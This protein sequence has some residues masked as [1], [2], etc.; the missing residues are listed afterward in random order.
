MD[1]KHKL[2][3]AQDILEQLGLPKKGR[4]KIAALTLFALAGLLPEDEWQQA[5]AQSLT[6]SKDIIDFVNTH[7]DAGYKANTR[8]SFRKDA[9]KPFVDYHIALLNPDDPELST[10]SSKTHYALSDK[11]LKVIKAYKTAGWDEALQEFK[12]QQFTQQEP[13]A[14]LLQKISIKNY[15]SVL[16]DTI[17]LGRFNV[18]IGANGCGKSNLLEAIAT[19]GAF[20]ANELTFEGLYARGVRTARPDLTF[21]SF[22]STVHDP[23]IDLSLQFTP[24]L[25]AH[26]L[27]LYPEHPD[28]IYTGWKN[29]NTDSTD[30]EGLLN[31]LLYMTHEMGENAP[32]AFMDSLLKLREQRQQLNAPVSMNSNLQRLLAEYAIFDLNTR[33]LRGLATDSRKTPLGINGE[34][35]DLLI[36]NFNSYERNYLAAFGNK[37]FE[38]LDSIHSDNEDKARQEGLKSGRSTSTLYFS[39]KF[40]Q[41]KNNTFSA[42]NSNE[43][44]LHT[45][46]YIALFI[47]NKTPRLFAIDNIETALNPKLCRLL[48]TILNQLAR[49]RGKQ[50]LITT[51]NPAVLDGMN[52]L[53]DEQRLFAVYRDSEGSTRTHRIKFK[54]E[55]AAKQFKLSEMWMKGSLGALPQNF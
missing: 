40:M 29:K 25:Y 3:E 17:E 36:A 45:L 31:R 50:A 12:Q 47:S 52:L 22:A 4:G 35:L 46:F 32:P 26:T 11:T 48:I 24:E 27:S 34:G 42:E 6:L 23:T 8:E 33:A 37:C 18:F 9:L 44:V 5:T 54:N 13:A 16:N 2:E 51:H 19:A 21:S 28:D 14:P 15:K 7:Y 53:D 39:D 20:V 43:G 38:W 10:N 55:L 41:K 49:E 30:I 1:H